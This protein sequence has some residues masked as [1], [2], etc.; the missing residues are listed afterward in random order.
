MILPVRFQDNIKN[1]FDGQTDAHSHIWMDGDHFIF[2]GGIIKYF[3]NRE[4]KTML[5][6]L[7][8]GTFFF[9]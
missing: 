1:I 9:L 4:I 8:M 6:V 5:N 3:V 7:S 2:G